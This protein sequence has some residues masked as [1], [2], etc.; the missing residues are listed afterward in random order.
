[1][2]LTVLIKTTVLFPQK[3]GIELLESS[4]HLSLVQL[5]SAPLPWAQPIACEGW[6]ANTV[7]HW[8]NAKQGADAIQSQTRTPNG[9]QS[10]PGNLVGAQPML[11]TFCEFEF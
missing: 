6:A 3:D 5:D 7:R 2:A 9:S 1:M 11:K 10:E 8:L 4:L